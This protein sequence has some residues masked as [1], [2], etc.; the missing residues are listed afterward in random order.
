MRNIFMETSEVDLNGLDQQFKVLALEASLFNDTKELF[1]S[2]VSKL[3]NLLTFSSDKLKELVS[4]N[5]ASGSKYEY[6]GDVIDFNKLQ[7]KVN[8]FI[9]KN[10]YITLH[11]YRKTL[12]EVPEGFKGN[13]LKYIDYLISKDTVLFNNTLKVIDDYNLMIG[14]V[15][16]NED[17]R[18]SLKDLTSI[19]SK[20]KKIRENDMTTVK[21][22]FSKDNNS[23]GRLSQLFQSKTDIRKLSEKIIKLDKLNSQNDINLI[24][25]A[26]QESIAKL[27]TLQQSIEN[28]EE[29]SSVASNNIAI[30]TKEIAMLTENIALHKFHINRIVQT[31]LNNLYDFFGIITKTHEFKKV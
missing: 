4:I 1:K 15:I 3:S 6:K 7:K 9:K 21:K 13:L 16:S 18:K 2:M 27:T 22:W 17:S 26:I 20:S 5:S 14:I 19:Y 24:N 12:I 31:S 23:K 30:G 8:E 28:G 25:T 11:D 10:D 29:I